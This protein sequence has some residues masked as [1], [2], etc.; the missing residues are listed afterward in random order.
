MTSSY[1]DTGA[2]VITSSNLEKYKTTLKEKPK[3]SDRD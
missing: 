2:K 1:V 3:E